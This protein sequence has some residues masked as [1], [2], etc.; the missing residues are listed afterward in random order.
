MKYFQSFPQI[1]T[2]DYVG[3]NIVL[4]NLMI[5]SEVVPGLLNNPLLFYSYDIQ[6]GDTP[7]IIADKY[8]GDPYRYWIVLYAN[9]L[10]DPQWSWPMNQNLFQDYI[11][12]KYTAAT[13]N[14]LHISANTVTPSQVMA[15]TQGTIQNYIKAVTTVDSYLQT[16]NTVIYIID[17]SAYANV[18]VNP[19]NITLDGALVSQTTSKYTQSI[20]DYELQQNEAKRNINLVNSIY[21]AQF[22]KQFKSLMS[23]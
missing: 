13:A 2:I 7:E 18:P 9:Q 15:Y 6:D 21:V 20:Y 3:N 17:S 19:V 14:S 5:R 22:E 16:P 10:L 1:V 4:T 12:D 8:Y 11:I 23:Q